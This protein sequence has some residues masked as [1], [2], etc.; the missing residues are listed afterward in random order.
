MTSKKR[1]LKFINDKISEQL[2]GH[3]MYIDPQDEDKE[4]HW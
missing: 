2:V 3:Y 1:A 4:Y